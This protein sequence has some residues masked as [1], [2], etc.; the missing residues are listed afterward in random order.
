MSQPFQRPGLRALATVP[1]ALAFTLSGCGGSGDTADEIRATGPPKEARP[2]A[3]VSPGLAPASPVVVAAKDEVPVTEYE[4][5]VDRPLKASFPEPA[6]ETARPD[7]PDL[8]ANDPIL[9][10]PLVIN[11]RVVPAEEVRTQVCMGHLGVIEIELAKLAIY[12]DEEIQRRLK[13][14]AEAHQLQV[15]EEEMAAF[16][17]ELEDLIDAE[18]P[19]QDMNVQQ[20]L[21]GVGG[22]PEERLRLTKLFGKIFLPEDPEKWPPITLEAVLKPDGNEAEQ[23][24]GKQVLDYYKETYTRR[25]SEDKPRPP[26]VAERE[27]DSAVLEQVIEHLNEVAR[28]EKRPAPG[29]L[30]KVN[31]VDIGVDEIWKRIAARVSAADVQSAKQWIVNTTLLREALEK[32]EAW[33]SAEEAD[34]A[35][36][37]ESDPYKKSMFSIERIA[38]A[39]KRF[40]SVDAYKEFH[41]L[42]ESY[43]RLVAPQMTPE[44]LKKHADARTMK[45][46][47]QVT[48]DVDVILCSAYDFKAQR[49]KENGWEEAEKR[50]KEVLHLLIDENRPWDELV[51]TYSE[52][53]EPAKG[54]Q[55]D[56]SQPRKGR[57][58]A[59]QRNPLLAQLGESEYW[60]FLNGTS[61]TDFIFFEQ[62]VG[63]LGDPMKGP[64]GWYL[65][66]LMRRSKPPPRMQVNQGTLDIL[67][68]EDYVVS[69]LNDYAQGLVAQNEVYGLDP[70]PEESR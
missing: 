59:I 64:N 63:T 10:K 58:R 27:F 32:Q 22:D 21:S 19:G 57:F 24:T 56:P 9:V 15:S 26:N 17:K 14:G 62:E 1:A 52:F 23:E 5:A 54:A 39:F 51:D 41:H 18:F 48:V 7:I 36:H 4:P 60:Q 28:I 33:L 20:L 29:V 69:H 13:G 53:P 67:I 8:P 34:A 50:M 25:Q 66:R 31:G 43:K 55:D 3:S 46:I 49:W 2:V 37:V 6:T 70:A 61:V 12:I 40:P 30:Y 42:L 11:G 16:K 47:G 44:E 45:M 68:A 35:Y 38:V 65:P